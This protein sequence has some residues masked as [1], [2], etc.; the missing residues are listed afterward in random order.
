MS[1]T[2]DEWI[3]KTDDTPIPQRVRLRVF[4]RAGGRCH[5]CGRKIA[6]GEYWECDHVIALCN[7]GENRE[8]NL[9]PACCNCC[10]PKTARDVSEKSKVNKKRLKHLGIRPRHRRPMPGSRESGIR[11]RMDGTVERWD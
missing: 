9:S 2:P 3:G 10:R 11:K 5:I 6:A 4:N 7:D 1:R 8:D